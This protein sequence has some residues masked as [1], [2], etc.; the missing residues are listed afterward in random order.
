MFSLRS[1]LI[2]VRENAWKMQCCNWR[3]RTCVVLATEKYVLLFTKNQHLALANR[4]C[5]IKI[6]QQLSKSFD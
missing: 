1:P 2:I 5:D 6:F 4:S 3:L